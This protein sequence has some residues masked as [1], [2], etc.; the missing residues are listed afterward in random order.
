[1]A[2]FFIDRIRRELT[3]TG[4]AVYE[5]ALIIAE[6]I[7]RKVQVLQLHWQAAAA[8]GRVQVAYQ[9]LGADLC[10]LLAR[11]SSDHVWSAA[12]DRHEA[13]QMLSSASIRIRDLKHTLQHV[14]HLI[15]ELKA[16]AVH[17]TLLKIQQDLNLRSATMER[18][19]IARGSA[20]V[21][22]TIGQL[23]LEP[24]TTVVAVL[25]GPLLVA[26]VE[27][28]VLHAEDI[29]VLAGSQTDLARILP[30]LQSAKTA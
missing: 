24:T 23:G 18:I 21:G 9:E 17:D 10:R 2:F 27:A 3:V 7:N 26:P 14:D 25:R 29:V 12:Q 22:Y 1:M 6:R 5:A 15:G 16:E 20:A 28:L 19:T 4:G 30:Y 13:A 8:T 11:S